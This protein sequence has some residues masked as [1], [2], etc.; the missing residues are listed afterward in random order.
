MHLTLKLIGIIVVACIADGNNPCK[1]LQAFVAPGKYAS[2]PCVNKLADPPRHHAYVRIHQTAQTG[3]NWPGV[4]SCSEGPTCFLYPLQTHDAIYIDGVSNGTGMTQP[5]LESSAISWSQ[6][7]PGVLLSPYAAQNAAASISIRSGVVENHA[8][9]NGMIYAEGNFDLPNQTLRI[10]AEGTNRQIVLRG[11]AE[12]DIINLE[13]VA[14]RGV[15]VLGTHA[16]TPHPEHFFL[17]YL[18][19]TAPPT[20][21]KAPPLPLVPPEDNDLGASVFCSNS[22]YP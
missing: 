13:P 5:F 22:N 20:D 8:A 10:I 17:H 21:C 9:K 14:A 16:H 18:L 2:Y 6:L 3:T 12:I 1:T 19:A 15:D 7:E 4:Q 11:D